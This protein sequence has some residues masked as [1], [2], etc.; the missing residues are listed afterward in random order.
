[1]PSRQQFRSST[2]RPARDSSTT[3]KRPE[4]SAASTPISRP[5]PDGKIGFCA[6]FSLVSGY[7]EKSK[8][9]G[10]NSWV[11]YLNPVTHYFVVS[12]ALALPGGQPCTSTC[13]WYSVSRA[14]RGESSSGSGSRRAPRT[15]FRVPGSPAET[16]KADSTM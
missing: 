9:V 15:G 10:T 3:T 16:G 8:W 12:V 14:C 7:L 13:N 6:G 1:M 11:S 4:T 5:C 2:V